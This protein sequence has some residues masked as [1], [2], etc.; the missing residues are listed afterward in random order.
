MF[1][2]QGMSRTRRSRGTDVE[3]SGVEILKLDSTVSVAV[4]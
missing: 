4:K 1:N 2:R 3:R